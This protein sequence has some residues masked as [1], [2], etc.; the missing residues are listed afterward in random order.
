MLDQALTSRADLLGEIRECEA[1]VASAR[2]RQVRLLRELGRRH[3]DVRADELAATLDVS[4]RTA[5][6]LLETSRRTPELS[7]AMTSLD[8]GDRSFDRAA[9]TAYLIGAGAD[10]ETVTEAESRDIAGVQ[11]LRSLQTR[12]TRRSERQA[13]QQRSVR[14]WTSLDSAVGFIHAE[15]GGYDWQTVT[16]ALE[17]RADHLPHDEASTARQRRADALV[18]LAHD[19]LS[20]DSKPHRSGSGPVVTV[21]VDPQLVAE[22]DGEAGAVIAAGPRIGPDTL[23]QILCEGSVEI[24]LDPT[25]GVPVAVG[26]T[27]RVV[28]PKV[29]RFVLARDGQCVIDGCDSTYRLQ[30]H[31]I[32]PRSAGGTHDVEN[33]T[34][35]C[36]WHHHVAIHGRGMR[37]DP[38]SPPQRRRLLP[39]GSDP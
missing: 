32:V 23:D 39:P 6:D 18:A 25:S 38:H 33:L 9:A 5:R 29:R 35:L 13:H 16:S 14:A 37:L 4:V 17:D 34:T 3:W 12:I 27:T 31:H 30:V 28:P 19:W 1:V 21:I 36:W 10:P 22:T 2:A 8:G 15:L 11:R 7:E 20:E 26:P 24:L